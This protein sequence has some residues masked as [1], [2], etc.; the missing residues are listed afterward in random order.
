MQYPFLA[1]PPLDPRDFAFAVQPD[2]ADLVAERDLVASRMPAMGADHLGA[3]ASLGMEICVPTV[4]TVPNLIFIVLSG[5]VGGTV[6]PLPSLP[7]R[8]M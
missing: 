3:L 2:W 7:S 4:R 1:H 6:E 8:S 5:T